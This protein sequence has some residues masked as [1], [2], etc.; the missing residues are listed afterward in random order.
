MAS[1]TQGAEAAGMPQ[2]DFS[3]FPNQMFWLVVSLVVVYFILSKIALP[4]IGGAL[5]DR[6]Q[7]ITDDL[8]AA[9]D[10]KQKA[11]EAEAAYEKALADARTQAQKIASD[12]RDEVQTQLDK[13]MAK[14]DAEISAKSEEAAKSLAEIRKNAMDN[15]KAV[16][17]DT[18]V[19]LVKAMG[20]TATKKDAGAAVTSRMKG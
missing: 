11:V 19:E 18:V 20:G 14:A 1:P 4:K 2:L 12:M 15:V 13:E 9:E 8:S 3:T 6:A 7:K 17:T 5:A 16:A 10:L